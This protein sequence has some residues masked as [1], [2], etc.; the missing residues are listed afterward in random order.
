LPG[1]GYISGPVD[2]LVAD[3]VGDLTL[4]ETGGAVVPGS[5]R[6]LV[7]EAKQSATLSLTVSYTQLYAQLFTL[8]NDDK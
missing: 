2:Y 5:R 7:V 6:F 1:I 3:T 8:Q 4:K